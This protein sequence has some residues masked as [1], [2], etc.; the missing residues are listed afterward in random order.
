MNFRKQKKL[1]I[2]SLNS[3]SKR[4]KIVPKTKE[5]INLLKEALSRED[6]KGLIEQ[7]IIKNKNKKGI[8]RTRAK[9]ILSQKN[10]GRRKGQGSRKGTHN[11]RDNSKRV[12][13]TKIRGLRASLKELKSSKKIVTKTYRNLYYKSKGNFFRNKK[14]LY[15]YLKQ[16]NLY[17]K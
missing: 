4:I 10:K 1:A 17:T 14:H 9:K 3:S 13:I 11:A 6:I 16:N 8:S 15:L 12:W 2:R 5:Q 7:K